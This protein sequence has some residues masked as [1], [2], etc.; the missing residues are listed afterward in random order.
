MGG[1]G[2]SNFSH[3]VFRFFMDDM[4]S[5]KGAK[6]APKISMNLKTKIN[7]S[8]EKF[9]IPVSNLKSVLCP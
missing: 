4:P 6:N 9:Y 7:N 8:K 2:G 1:G 5:K 3:N